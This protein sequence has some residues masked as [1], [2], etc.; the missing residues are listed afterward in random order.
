ML[1]RSVD[2][3]QLKTFDYLISKLPSKQSDD[4]MVVEFGEKS[5]SK[6]GQ[7]PFDRRDIASVIKKL[8]ENNAGIII[9]PILFSEKD[10]AGGDDELSRT[11]KDNG[12]VIAQ[13]ATTQSHKPDAVRRGFSNIGAVDPSGF[14]FNWSGGLGPIASMAESAA[15][16]GTIAVAPERDGVTRRLPLL[17]GIAGGTYPSLVLEG[18]RVAT[19]ETSYQIKTSEIGIEAVRVPN[20]PPITTD[21]HGRIWLT[22][23]TKFDKIDATE[24]DKRVDGKTIILGNAIEGAGGVIAT[25][26][27]EKWAYELQAQALQTVLDRKSTRLN[28]SHTDISRMPSSA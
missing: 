13:T 3:A 14:I 11:I 9:A 18:I 21:E 10:R 27:G 25:P 1:F 2:V 28:S 16:V 7:W 22:W 5:V 20:I 12:V 26:V 17:L 6:F 23:N 8:R 4:I 24:I 19:G 15:G